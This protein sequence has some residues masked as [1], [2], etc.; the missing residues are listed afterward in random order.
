M[1]TQLD[2]SVGCD[3]A[4]CGRGLDRFDPDVTQCDLVHGS[5]ECGRVVTR[6]DLESH[7]DLAHCGG[8]CGHVTPRDPAGRDGDL[9]DLS[10]LL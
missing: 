1:V 7:C 10:D 9:P 5:G 8:G 3:L 2:P 4:Q 6:S